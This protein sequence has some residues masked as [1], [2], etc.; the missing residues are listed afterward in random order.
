M[1]Y[2]LQN[3]R[4]F[5]VCPNPVSFVSFK[6]FQKRGKAGAIF[7][8]QRGPRILVRFRKLLRLLSGTNETIRVVLWGGVI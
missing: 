4:R 8:S 1:N 7:S 3:V 2:L 5:A 6:Q